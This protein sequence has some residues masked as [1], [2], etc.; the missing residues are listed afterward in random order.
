MMNEQTQISRGAKARPWVVFAG[1]CLLMLSVF[2]IHGTCATLLVA[3]VTGEMGYTRA[4]FTLGISIGSILQ[5][6]SAPLVAKALANKKIGSRG[7]ISIALVLFALV[8]VWLSRATH[9]WQW[10]VGFTLTGVIQTFCASIVVQNLLNNWF[11]DRLGFVIGA[12]AAMSGLGGAVFSPIVSNVIANSGWRTACI[13]MAAIVVVIGLPLAATVLRFTPQECGCQPYAAAK[14]KAAEQQASAALTGMTRSEALRSP[15]FYFAFFASVMFGFSA[16]INTHAPA[17]A[18]KTF[19]VVTMGSMVALFSV[20]SALGKILL[21]VINDK[22]GIYASTLFGA[23]GMVVGTLLMI[24]SSTKA[25]LGLMYVAFALIGLGA[26]TNTLTPP[27]IVTASMGR[28]SF[29]DIYGLIVPA[30]V[31]GVAVGI[32]VSGLIYDKS[33]SYNVALAS[34][35]AFSVLACVCTM[36]AA[37]LGKKQLREMSE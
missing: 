18:A 20:C 12:S 25:M 35:I 29:G 23:F 26:S 21:G 11:Q 16:A 6:F 30:F 15:V 36:I 28:K 13:V 17:I 2:T 1:C 34:I 7:V 9:V 32:P 22:L 24:V 3:P 8:Y 33:G 4:E 10:Q 37:H 27:L 31:I 19:D 5:I 14:K